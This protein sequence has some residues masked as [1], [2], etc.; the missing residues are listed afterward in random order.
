MQVAELGL[1]NVT[2][3]PQSYLEQQNRIQTT[4]SALSLFANPPP[5]LFSIKPQHT[6]EDESDQEFSRLS[7]WQCQGLTAVWEYEVSCLGT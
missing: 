6:K 7:H 4:N 5:F 3:F 1:R 2:I